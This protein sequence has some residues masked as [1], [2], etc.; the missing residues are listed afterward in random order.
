MTREILLRAI[1]DRHSVRRYTERQIEEEKRELLNEKIAEINE[2]SGFRIQ[3]FF[4]EPEAFKATR[5]HYG[6]F[7]GCRNYFAIVGPSDE[8]E[9]AGYFGEE[10][11][12]YAQ[13]IGLNTCWVALTFEKRKV[14][15][16]ASEDFSLYLVISLGYGENEG[17]AHRSKTPEKVSNI[18]ENSPEWFK[19]GVKAALL[20]PTAINQQKFY[21]EQTGD[22]EVSARALAGPYSELDL[23][24]VKYHFEA[25]AGRENFSWKE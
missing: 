3:V 18:S 12:L 21:I 9:K 11:V 4:D 1:E 7:K 13:S 24:I 6:S 8:K 14:K 20:A 10:L 23:G 22:R 25:G 15:I 19:N 5:P 16:N 2:R 17:N